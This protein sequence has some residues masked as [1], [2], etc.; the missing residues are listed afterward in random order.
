MKKYQRGFTLIE[1]MIVIS[2]IGILAAIAIPTY[3]NYTERTA[4]NS[5]L[6]ELKFYS[7]LVLAEI[8]DRL[9][10]PTPANAAC[11]NTTDASTFTAPTQI[12][13]NPLN[14]GTGTVTCSPDGNCT[15]A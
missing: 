5:C 10:P 13:G 11:E 1:L 9:I 12:T 6:A 4:N 8:N 15:H 3:A 2:I 14:P 7:N